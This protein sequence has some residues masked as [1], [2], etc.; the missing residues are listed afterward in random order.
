MKKDAEK[1]RQGKASSES[2]AV[3]A[4]FVKPGATPARREEP[5]EKG[6]MKSRRENAGDGM[7]DGMR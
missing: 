3:E 5:R 4:R 2:D 1:G 6:E 7:G